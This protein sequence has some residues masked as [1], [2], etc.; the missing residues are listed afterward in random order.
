MA[1]LSEIQK[2]QSHII[3]ICN[4]IYVTHTQSSHTSSTP[5]NGKESSTKHPAGSTICGIEYK[6]NLHTLITALN[7]IQQVLQCNPEVKSSHG[8]FFVQCEMRKALA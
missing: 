6:Y 1:V 3:Y 4:Y 5:L 7:V 2:V 8:I